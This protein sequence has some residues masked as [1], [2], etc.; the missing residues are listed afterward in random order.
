MLHLIIEILSGILGILLSTLLI[1]QW[2]FQSPFYISQISPNSDDSSIS[3]TSAPHSLDYHT[4]TDE[5]SLISKFQKDITDRDDR[6]MDLAQTLSKTESV[7]ESEL[8]GLK[9][10]ISDLQTINGQK[11]ELIK[12]LE[13]ENMNLNSQLQ[14]FNDT[15][16]DGSII[17][18]RIIRIKKEE[19]FTYK[20]NYDRISRSVSLD[21]RKIAKNKTRRS[22][23]ETDILSHRQAPE[24][25]FGKILKQQNEFYRSTINHLKEKLSL[26]SKEIENL[27]RT[28]HTLRIRRVNHSLIITRELTQLKNNYASLK[29]KYDMKDE[30]VFS[31]NKELNELKRNNL[32]NGQHDKMSNEAIKFFSPENDDRTSSFLSEHFKI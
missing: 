19:T 20:G 11:S 6:I 4:L 25:I 30:M 23:S 21:S 26:K 31:L 29:A 22:R 16:Q 12:M 27:Y 10:Q 24:D 28:L 14:I 2:F 13:L 1:K 8:C 5:Q 3:G 17:P 32:S 7:L 15:K 18:D 9:T